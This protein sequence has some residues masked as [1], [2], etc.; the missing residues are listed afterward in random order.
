MKIYELTKKY[1]GFEI[2]EEN[3]DFLYELAYPK[4]KDKL[5]RIIANSG[6]A[7]GQRLQ[8]FYLAQLIKEQIMFEINTAHINKT[9]YENYIKQLKQKGE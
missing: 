1:L 9:G 5:E 8:D 4:A 3:F 2:D 6:D 7:T